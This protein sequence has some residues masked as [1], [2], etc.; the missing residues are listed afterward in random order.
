MGQT[1]LLWALTDRK[2]A[3]NCLLNTRGPATSKLNS[4]D[5]N[6][7][8]FQAFTLGIQLVAGMLDH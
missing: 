5:Q 7:A 2:Q 4:N 3:I 8:R 1:T 6:A